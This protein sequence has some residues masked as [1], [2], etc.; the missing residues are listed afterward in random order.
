MLLKFFSLWAENIRLSF[1]ELISNKLRSFLSLL[2]IAIGI[3]CIVAVFTAVDS[4]KKNL[5]D[6][7]NK[8]GSH[9]VM[10]QKWP[11]AFNEPNYAWWKYWN[12]PVPN[13]YEMEFLK[14]E[15]AS[16]KEADI[17]VGMGNKTIKK[18]N[19]E[20]DNMSLSAST[21]SF[22]LM[23]DMEFAAGRFFSASEEITAQPLVVLGF[24]VAQ[25]LSPNTD[26]LIDNEVI[27]A[28]HRVKV[29]GVL[30]KVGNGMF[31]QINDNSILIGYNFLKTFQKMD[32][33][34]LDATIKL[35]PRDGIDDDEFKEDLQ[36]ELRSIRRLRPVQENNFAMNEMSILKTGFN[37][38]FVQVNIGGFFIGLLSLLIGAFGIA[39]I[40][41]VSVRERTKQI[42]IKKA[43]GAKRS[44]ILFEFLIESVVLSLLGGIMGVG[45]VFILIKIVSFSFDFNLILTMKNV[46]IGV[47]TSTVIGLLAGIIPAY[48]AAKLDPVKAIR[49]N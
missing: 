37:S 41:F 23:N 24:D 44:E 29:I 35:V 40:M 12:R 31:S 39:N 45:I 25:Q 27:L 8:L 28:K 22:A 33:L 9:F 11:W 7:L 2:G 26:A 3:F 6:G 32:D 49:T 13:R 20:L 19:V 38:M 18:G 21:A 14:Q 36:R 46:L 30:K 43:I 42:G 10:I 15:V 16:C 5:D 48:F 47:A 4:I 34:N 1:Q 17:I